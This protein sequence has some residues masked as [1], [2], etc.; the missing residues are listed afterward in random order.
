MHAVSRA[1]AAGLL[2][3]MPQTAKSTAMSLNIPYK[4]SR[5]LFEIEKNLLIGS[6]YF[7]SLLERYDNNRILALASY[8][9][10]PDRVSTWLSRSSGKLTFDLWIELIPFRETRSYVKSVLMYSAIYSHKIGSQRRMLEP[11]EIELL[12]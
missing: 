8:N 7:K 6:S 11:N 1:G 5:Q 9:A 4:N 3:I 12:L 10:G 2:Q